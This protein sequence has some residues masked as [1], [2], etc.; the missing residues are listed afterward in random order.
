M[1]PIRFT[2]SLFVTID[3]RQN[4]AGQ[5]CAIPLVYLFSL[6]HPDQLAEG[7]GAGIESSNASEL[8]TE[9]DDVRR[10]FC[11]SASAF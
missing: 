2:P 5:G 1:E 11:R 6:S 10:I 4:R 3:V 8:V 7:E 9:P